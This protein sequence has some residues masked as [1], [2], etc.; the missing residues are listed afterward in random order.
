MG[1]TSELADDSG[2]IIGESEVAWEQLR[3]AIVMNA[4]SEVA[5]K[6]A[7]W[8]VFTADEVLGDPMLL[9]NIKK[10]E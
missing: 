4:D 8:M 3:V 6:Q 10:G 1:S 5:L 7:E 9:N 2:E